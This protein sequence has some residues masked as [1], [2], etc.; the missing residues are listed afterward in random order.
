[1]TK[2]STLLIVIF[3]LIVGQWPL[4]AVIIVTAVKEEVR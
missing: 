4:V 1:M 3:T 2:K